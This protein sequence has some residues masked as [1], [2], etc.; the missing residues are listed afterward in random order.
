MEERRCWQKIQRKGE[1][2]EALWWAGAG[3]GF[4]EWEATKR[5]KNGPSDDPDHHRWKHHLPTVNYDGRLNLTETKAPT[6]LVLVSGVGR[7]GKLR[8]QK[9]DAA[10]T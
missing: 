4:G 2:R 6:A 7:W 9:V 10:L 3:R 8:Q 5:A 1:L